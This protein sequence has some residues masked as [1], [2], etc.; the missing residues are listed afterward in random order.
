MCLDC[1]EVRF[2]PKIVGARRLYQIKPGWNCSV[3]GTCLTVADLRALARKF[4]VQFEDCRATDY[5][6]H[7]YFVQEAAKD[8]KIGKSLNK[9]L[10]RRHATAIKRIHKLT[11]IADIE[12]AWV[13]AFKS[14]NIPGPYW[15]IMSHGG[16]DLD[17]EFATRVYCEVHMLSHLAGSSN[18]SDLAAFNTME[19]DLV[20][21]NEKRARQTNS[22][23]TRLKDKNQ[24]IAKLQ[25]ENLSL[26][27]GIANLECPIQRNCASEK[28]KDCEPTWLLQKVS[29]I[30][31]EN[32]G[33]TEEI[34]ALKQS[35]TQLKAD[36]DVLESAGFGDSGANH[37]QET[38]ID[39]SGRNILYVGGRSAQVMRFRDLVSNWN[40]RLSHHDGG[41]EKSLEELAS[42]VTKS[43]AV[44]F[45]TDC[46][47]HE[48][49]L[50]VKKLC[51]N[52]MKP[53]V[54]LRRSGLASFV[55]GLRDLIPSGA[56]PGEAD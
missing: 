2:K 44:I 18:C 37:Q 46:I 35:I 31:A 12:E 24:Q 48:A 19:Q 29:N 27:A 13:A 28:E 32:N 14:G 11:D 6:Y 47:S 30:S 53:F 42:A 54:P 10:N 21:A 34:A 23:R 16:I 51:R 9:L 40:G 7:G 41:L 43:D 4:K 50:R 25:S 55:S 1:V 49:A 5:N 3:V 20:L 56:L 15:A 38:E 26:R 36:I 45:P 52:S 17:S 39:L 8:E 22:H 33:L